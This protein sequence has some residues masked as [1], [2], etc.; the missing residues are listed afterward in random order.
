MFHRVRRRVG[1]IGRGFFAPLAIV[2]TIL[3]AIGGIGWTVS[4][5]KARLV[6]A[7]GAAV[8][9]DGSMLTNAADRGVLGVPAGFQ[10][11]VR[12]YA[13]GD[14]VRRAVL[15]APIHACRWQ[16]PTEGD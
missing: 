3:L 6:E 10:P 16:A 12:R 14:G 11:S 15:R 13:M 2:L 7:A 9:L 1:K 4:Q 8:W 5:L